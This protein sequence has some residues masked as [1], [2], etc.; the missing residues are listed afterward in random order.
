MFDV[1]DYRNCLSSI[2]KE[3]LSVPHNF[4][5]T[6]IPATAYTYQT[7]IGIRLL[8]DWLS[9]PAMYSWVNFEAYEHEDARGLD[10]IVAQRPDGL[11]E[12]VQ[13]KFTVDP[14]DAGNLLS[15]SWLL[16]RKSA[17]GTSLLEK[18]S[19]ATR[20]VGLVKIGKVG[21]TTNRR[22]D[23][24]FCSHLLDGKINL[25]SLPEQLR[26]DVEAQV[27][28]S[29][30]AELFFKRFE[31]SHSYV[32]YETLD[33]QLSAELES[34]HTDHYGWLAL[35]RQA[36]DWSIRRDSPPPDGRITLEVLRATISERQ[37]RPLDQE[38]RIPDGYVPPDS[39]F[40]DAFVDGAVSGIWTLRVVWG[41]PGQG[42][43]TF[44]SYFCSRLLER[45]LPFVR[46]HYFLS[47]RDHC[48]RFSL[49]SV[50]HSLI[51]QMQ[52]CQVTGQPPGG[53]HPEDLRHWLEAYGNAYSAIGKRFFVV[54]DGLDH[55]WRENG[56]SIE[57]LAA[58]FAQLLP[59]PTNISLI[60]GSQRVDSVQLPARLNTYAER[61]HWVELPRMRLGSVKAWLDAQRTS[62]TFQVE[63]GSA[64]ANEM[65]ELALEF[66]RISSGHPLV[67]TYTF[68]NLVRVSPALTARRIAE[69]APQPL[70]D[71]LAYY[72][73]LWQRLSWHA[74]DALHLMARDGFIWP[75][76]ALDVC[77]R[78]EHSTLEVEI[79]H[80]LANVDAGLIAFHGSLYVFVSRQA[81]HEARL[82]SLLPNVRRWLA[83][84]APIYLRWAW[85]CLYESRLGE[86]TA[87][88]S[89]T[90]RAWAIAA[91]TQAYPVD[92]IV[93]ILAVAEEI[94]FALGDYE[95][96][97]QKRWLKTRI[98]SGLKYQLDDPDVLECH[99][100]RLTRDSYPALLLASEVNQAS[101]EGL[102]QFA[103]LC[104]SLGQLK[105]AT[106]VQ[107]RMRDKINDRIRLGEV[108]SGKRDQMLDLYLEVAA[109]TGDYD[110]ANIL[111][112]LQR[113]DRAEEFFERFL[114][115]ASLGVNL[116]PIMAFV[117]QPMALRLRRIVEVEAVR[118]SA[119]T[120]AKLQD[121][122]QFD[123]FKK[124][125]LSTC[126]RI[127][128]Q[129]SVEVDALPSIKLHKALI[130]EFCSYDES[131]FA[132]YLHFAFFASVA[133]VLQLQGAPL[134]DGLGVRGKR[135]WLNSALGKLGSAANACGALLV[136][137][138]YPAFSLVYRLVDLKTPT[139]GEETAWSDRRSLT[140]ALTLITA[141]LF[142]LCR[143]RSRLNY[144]PPN[145]WA[146]SC[147]H[148]LFVLHYWRQL[149]LT[150]HFRLLADDVVSA[151]IEAQ[152]RRALNTL[153]LFNEKADE[154]GNLCAWATTYG[155]KELGERLL[156][157]AYRYA[158][159]YGWRKDWRLPSILDAVEEVSRYDREAASVALEKLAPIYSDIDKMTED[160]GANTSDLACL[161]LKLMPDA[162]VRLY[163]FLLDRSDWFD[164]EKAFAA[165]V[166]T[167]DQGT[168]VVDVVSAFLWDEA[169]RIKVKAG[170]N[171]KLDAM[172]LVWSEGRAQP[173]ARRD[174]NAAA[175][176]D[177]PDDPAIPL[178]E[179]YPP[180]M[181]SD[182]S[183]AIRESKRYVG[184]E[185]LYTRWFDHWRDQGCGVELLEAL[186][187]AVKSK[188]FGAES[189][190]LDRAFN[191]S[192][193]LKG[194]KMS[195]HWLVEAHRHRQGWFE[196][197]H[198]REESAKRIALLAVHYPERW[199]E[200][201]AQTSKPVTT[202]YQPACVIP[203]VALVGLLLQVGK[204]P[205]AVSVLRAIVDCTVEEFEAQPLLR[206]Q[207]LD[208][209]DA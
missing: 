165:F 16:N 111:T 50:A 137:G 141:D 87:L 37:P 21:L 78:A 140:E 184:S 1:A 162:Y 166:A 146:K 136:R 132:H 47:L 62:G 28:G 100:L 152:E 46:H 205:R 55:V 209:S 187:T 84:K 122:A 131:E 123:R 143:P 29:T 154:L 95:L 153:G 4:K 102:H 127:L 112:L 105:R 11:L 206:P 101:V 72:Q 208:G 192:L 24:D 63:G 177:D 149:F 159:A 59:L 64:R 52:A 41:S 196:D 33:R 25:T 54:I 197:Y 157:A 3:G 89:G 56:E 163:R 34:F 145:E 178:I 193:K 48:D 130:H 40:A 174:A 7:L 126:W 80:L 13:V 67:L 53:N 98:E 70:G 171:S 20:R 147:E 180:Q 148:E 76:G 77:L 58:L 110:P 207:W 198:G 155:L 66:E 60:L 200:F 151:Q 8:C 167:I 118:T 134:H 93:R 142:L 23:A 109:G 133:Q 39:E 92:Q 173:K 43:S 190:L 168:P 69:H 94:A 91:L 38:F 99:G 125:P 65:A 104:L 81:D 202:R 106:E 117:L 191:L 45:G 2:K 88:L 44:L 114:R 42:K 17:K 96:A 195:F 108:S 107:R 97:I 179:K 199:E 128:Y 194:R 129:R 156:A 139:K 115:N 119:W 90:T 61:E 103:K 172:M 186:T 27:G 188:E 12:L 74:K 138:E 10:D 14:F 144:I 71:A 182:F 22:P 5:P 201:V 36:I 185:R 6:A 124:H 158:L 30:N 9:N 120:Q 183:A 189:V 203:D 161:L 18:W 82:C 116:D 204:I 19:A 83:D 164:A 26:K 35:Y 160:S 113:L 169:S 79:G 135:N 68:L 75:V 51:T 175:V 73:A 170:V 86:N 49:K 85:L 150:R 181:L 57:P 32:G 176:A 121:W 15:W 31:F